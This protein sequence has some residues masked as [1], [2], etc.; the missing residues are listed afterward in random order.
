[1]PEVVEEK[2]REYFLTEVLAFLQPVVL[3]ANKVFFPENNKLYFI[4]NIADAAGKEQLVLLNIPSD[5]LKRF[6]TIDTGAGSYIVFLDDIIRSHLDK[7]F[8]GQEI[9]GCYSIKVTRD[10]ELDLKDEYSGDV[11]DEIEK[12]LKKEGLGLS[13]TLPAPIRYPFAY[14]SI[15]HSA[16]GYAGCQYN[17]GRQVS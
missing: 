16:P 13:Y 11:S 4:V 6:F 9:K 2:A 15:D 14:S 5:E 1:M 10:A 3:Q 7:V 12:Q 8:S 17:G